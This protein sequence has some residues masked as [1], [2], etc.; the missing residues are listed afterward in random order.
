[1]KFVS[2]SSGSSGNATFVSHNNIKLIID[3]GISLK[4]LKQRLKDI[5]EEIDNID[6]LFLTHCHDDHIKCLATLMG[7]TDIKVYSR[8]QILR[9]TIDR[10]SKD[11]ITLDKNRFFTIPDDCTRIN[12]S[13]GF[14]ID[15]YEA[16]HDVRCVYYKFYCDDEVLAILTDNGHYDD[17]MI[18]SLKDVHYLMLECNYDYDMLMD[19]PHYPSYL[20]SRIAGNNGHLSNKACCEIIKSIANDKLKTVC[21]SHVSEHSNTEEYALQYVK[22]YFAKEPNLGLPKIIV[23]SRHHITNIV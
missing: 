19:Y 13:E 3:C 23:A 14:N 4:M 9:D 8:Q 20:K 15:I 21:L 17:D 12:I 11:I 7:S 2:L 6:Y 18:N 10:L 16:Y 5:D 1:M 22:E